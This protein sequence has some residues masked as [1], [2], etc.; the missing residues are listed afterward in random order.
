MNNAIVFPNVNKH[1]KNNN[2]CFIWIIAS[3]K[4]ITFYLFETARIQIFD[5]PQTATIANRYHPPTLTL[6]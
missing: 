5:L 6:S 1:D 3:K 4:L 2:F